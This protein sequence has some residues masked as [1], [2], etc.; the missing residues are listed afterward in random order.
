V[1]GF[2]A[3]IV[4]GLAPLGSLQAGWLGE[5]VGVRAGAAMC[6]IICLGTALVLSKR[7]RRLIAPLAGERR[8]GGEEAATYRWGERRQT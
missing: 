3:F 1:I 2:Y 7:V 6:G 8:Q 5:R 4:V